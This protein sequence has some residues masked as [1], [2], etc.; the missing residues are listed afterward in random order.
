MISSLPGFREPP[1]VD[2]RGVFHN[3]QFNG[4]GCSVFLVTTGSDRI[5]DVHRAQEIC[6]TGG[7][8]NIVRDFLVYM[9]AA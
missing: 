5:L 7:T 9:S 4:S 8:S 1:G 3:H 6:C 2:Y